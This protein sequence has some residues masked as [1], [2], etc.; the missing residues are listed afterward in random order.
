MAIAVEDGQLV[1]STGLAKDDRRRIL[2]EAG[3][4][5]FSPASYQTVM[6]DKD[7]REYAERIIEL[8]TAIREGLGLAGTLFSDY[9]NLVGLSESIFAENAYLLG[10]ADGQ[11]LASSDNIRHLKR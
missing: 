2:A 4:R 1:G 11:K 10:L 5:I 7:Y 8:G 6:D 9:E 3:R